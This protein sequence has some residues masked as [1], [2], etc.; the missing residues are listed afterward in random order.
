MTLFQDTPLTSLTLCSEE[1]VSRF[2]SSC[3]ASVLSRNEMAPNYFWYMHCYVG[4]HMQLHTGSVTGALLG[5]VDDTPI[6]PTDTAVLSFVWKSAQHQVQLLR[7][8]FHTR[9]CMLMEYC[10]KRIGGIFL[11]FDE[12]RKTI[13]L[14]HPFVPARLLLNGTVAWL[15]AKHFVLLK[16]VCWYERVEFSVP[17]HLL[18]AFARVIALTDA[19]RVDASVRFECS[20]GDVCR[21]YYDYTF[22][23]SL[24]NADRISD[25]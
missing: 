14:G 24:I 22:L 20:M 3:R 6:T 4:T 11:H 23:T 25:F 5:V 16:Y 21:I 7:D 12:A 19:T 18:A 2:A 15:I 8:D 10:G 13:V 9:R 17:P 1:A